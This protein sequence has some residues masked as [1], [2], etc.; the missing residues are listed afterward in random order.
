[1]ATVTLLSAGILGI[2]AFPIHVEIDISN[3]L[4]G[5]STV[6]LPE[7]TVRE[8][9]DRVIAAIHN[10]GYE[11]PFR[12]ITLN[13]APADVKKQGTAYDLPI[14]L[15]LLA[16]SEVIDPKALDGYVLMGE[17]S[18]HGR[19]RPVRGALAVA[20]LAK[21]KGWKGLILP[22][23][24]APEAA[25][26]EG[27]DVRS[28]VDL[29][30]VVEFLQDQKDLPLARAE[31]VL[32]AENSAWPDFSE[33]KG[34]AYA[35]RALEIAA[36]G[37]HPTMMV[38]PPGSGKSLLASTLPSILTELSFEESLVTSRIHA[39][40]QDK[41]L[42]GGL[43]K[44]RPFRSPH[45][46]VSEAGLIGGGSW[47]R[48]GEA[49]LAHH[50]VLFLD[51]LPEFRRPALET[52]RQ[53]LETHSVT[54]VRARQRL[55]FPARFLLVAAMNPCPCGQF[56][57]PSG[58]CLCPDFLIQRYQSRISGPLLDRFDLKVEVPPLAFNEL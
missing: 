12:R 16:A 3:G 42:D 11:F 58:R 31:P 14:A 18:L 57:Q 30:A 36:A 39:V 13:L 22:R 8:S 38:G 40:C 28:A 4:P 15:G 32:E 20:L 33:V 23:E 5:W 49:S 21:Q 53:P 19:L 45:H 44:R 34:Q 47:P 54:I 46:S 43:M 52:L 10:C 51:E 50:G 27:L 24:S 7:S 6:G 35:K 48:P 55:T 56:G 2:D 37:F 41:A 9:K 26:I 17:L 29:P 1:M 25:L